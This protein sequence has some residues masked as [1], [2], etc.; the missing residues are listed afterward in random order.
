MPYLK[1]QVDS[2]RNFVSFVQFFQRLLLCT[3]LAQAIYIYFAQKEPIKMKIF[4]TFER[5]GQILSN[6]LCQFFNVSRFLYKFS[7]PL[8]FHERQVLDTFLA[9][10][11]CTLLIRSPLKW[12][13]W[14]LSSAQVKICQIPYASFE[15]RSLFLSKFCIL[16]PVSWNITPPYFFSSNNIYFAQ[17][18]PIEME[19]FET[20]ERLGQILSN[21]LCQ[22]WNEKSIPLQILYPS[23]S[24]MKDYSSVLFYLKQY[25]LCSKG[26][27]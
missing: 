26:A 18:E 25:I 4:E 9:Q 20:L 12:K 16:L 6:Y 27:H 22:F 21:F 17:K 14:G 2:S 15:T 24:F 11:I 7:I 3:F 8:Q 1:R 19:I 23:S 10:T 13:F 5:S